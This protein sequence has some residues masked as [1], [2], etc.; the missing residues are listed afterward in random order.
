[1]RGC[2]WRGLGCEL[3]R[4]CCVHGWA[5]SCVLCCCHWVVS[6]MCLAQNNKKKGTLLCCIGHHV[7]TVF[8]SEMRR[9][10][11]HAT[12]LLCPC[13]LDLCMC[14]WGFLCN[15][16]HLWFFYLHFIFKVHLCTLMSLNSLWFLTFNV[17]KWVLEVTCPRPLFYI[18]CYVRKHGCTELLFVRSNL[19]ILTTYLE[20]TIKT[21]VYL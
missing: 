2:W 19:D 11:R 17:F 20:W 6:D 7:G 21:I 13:F 4:R 15:N 14:A 16:V 3:W 1:M 5:V 12:P 18:A 10:P 8:V 9:T